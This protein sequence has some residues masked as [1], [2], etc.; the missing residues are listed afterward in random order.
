MLEKS[1][2]LI[3]GA[4]EGGEAGLPDTVS[5]PMRVPCIGRASGPGL[6]GYIGTEARQVVGETRAHEIEN[7]PSGAR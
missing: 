1:N 4:P 6:L 7:H 3:S 5:K 2:A